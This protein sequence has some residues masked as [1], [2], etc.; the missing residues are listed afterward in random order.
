M[1]PTYLVTK[2]IKKYCTVAL[3]G[4]GG[5][6]LFGGY[7]HYSRLLWTYNLLKGRPGLIRNLISNLSKM[8][9]PIGFRGRNWLQSLSID[10]NNS[11]P[12]ISTFFDFEQ[13]KLLFGGITQN[14][15]D[16]IRKS[17]IPKE[18]DL[19][20]RM[21]MMDFSTYLVEDILVKVD[22]ASMLNSLEVRAPLLDYRLIELAFKID[23]PFKATSDNKKIILK[24][25]ARTILPKSFNFNRKQGFSIPLTTWLTHGKWR[26]FFED[27]LFDK[28]CDLNQ[29]VIK[30]LFKG[31]DKGMN[32]AER[33]F[34]LLMLELWIKK[35]KISL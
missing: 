30:N 15:A 34:G 11:L 23:S 26:N 21:T 6:E 13:R 25:Y 24:E 29:N 32:N 22:R 9:L 7:M 4:D 28:D 12:I 17:M 8:L 20:K 27:V 14:V 31:L 10:Y 19:L 2:E 35:Y 16:N 33:I 18:K 1:V 3:G 5:D